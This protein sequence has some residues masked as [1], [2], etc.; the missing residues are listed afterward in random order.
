MSP[1]NHKNRNIY[2]IIMLLAGWF[3]LALQLYLMVTSKEATNPVFTRVINFFSFFTILSNI[4]VAVN[5]TVLVI[6]PST[7]INTPSVQS[8]LAVYI[9]IVGITYSLVLRKLWHPQGWQL[10][11]DVLLHD[12]IPVMYVVYWLVFVPKGQLKWND[13][14][15]W[16]L[17]PFVYIAYTLLRGAQ[18]CWYPYPFVDAHALGYG[19][20]WLNVLLFSAAFLL[21]GKILVFLDKMIAK[22]R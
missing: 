18:T 5:C 19:K 3:A 1:L 20:V 15:R 4:L 16:L 9:A 2:L 14:L 21:V 11:A 12:V 22:K 13:A 7:R 8:A 6:K 17:F 10:V